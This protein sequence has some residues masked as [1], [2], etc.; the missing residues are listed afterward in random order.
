M[1]LNRIQD[2]AGYSTHFGHLQ[3]VGDSLSRLVVGDYDVIKSSPT[4]ACD[5]FIV[6]FLLYHS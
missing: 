1:L 2:D 6:F 4:A 5:D 3:E